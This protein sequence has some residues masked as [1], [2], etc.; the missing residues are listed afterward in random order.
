MTL[1]F[2]IVQA[3]ILFIFT[4]VDPNKQVEIV[5]SEGS[6]I[7]HRYVCDHKTP[8]FFAVM[9]IY[10]GGL[11]LVGCVLAFKTRHLQSEFNESKQIILAMY[12]IAVVGSILLVVSNVVVT[13][14]GPKR[15][16]FAVGIFWATCFAC[17]V[18]VVPRLLQVRQSSH[19]S[20]GR[21]T[22]RSRVQVSGVSLGNQNSQNQ[23]PTSTSI[24]SRLEPVSEIESA[25]VTNTNGSG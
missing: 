8:A 6:D 7:S 18:F 17:S 19:T 10:E 20:S 23:T 14:Q 13:Y 4:F 16:L 21:P 11:I 1:P 25:V 22:M 3:A 5:E 9:L 15:I 12:D 2:V 24:A